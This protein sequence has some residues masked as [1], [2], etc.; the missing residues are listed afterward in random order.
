MTGLSASVGSSRF[1]TAAKNASQST[2]AIAS[3]S[4][5]GCVRRRGDP[6]A[7]QR[8]AGE[9]DSARQSRQNGAPSA[10]GLLEV[11]GRQHMAGFHDALGLRGDRLS[12]G[13]EKILVGRHMVQHRSQEPGRR[14][15]L[16]DRVGAETGEAEETP[17]ALLIGRE[18]GKRA[19]R[20]RFRLLGGYFVFEST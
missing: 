16:P 18:H 19:R 5:S 8:S 17:Q 4:R 15:G 13:K 7:R 11:R 10:M 3:E 14:G 12:D 6:Q 1:S 9:R 2:W 20:D